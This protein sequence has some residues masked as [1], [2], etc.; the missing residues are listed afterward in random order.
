[1]RPTLN[2]APNVY[3]FMAPNKDYSPQN[4][5]QPVHNNKKFGTLCH[6]QITS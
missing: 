1:M 3:Y 6:R 5:E 2:M 4:I